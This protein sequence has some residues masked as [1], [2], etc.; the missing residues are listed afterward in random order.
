MKNNLF[1]EYK[2]FCKK[3]EL[4]PSH[5]SSLS[6]F[7]EIKNFAKRGGLTWIH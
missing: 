4:S 7:A 2:E 5:A 6:K 3:N 1:Y